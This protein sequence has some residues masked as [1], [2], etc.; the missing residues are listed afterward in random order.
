MTNNITWNYFYTCAC[1]CVFYIYVGYYYYF[2]SY[3]TL[4]WMFELSKIKADKSNFYENNLIIYD[5]KIRLVWDYTGGI[6]LM[7]NLRLYLM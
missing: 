7:L 2:D 5:T 6:K 1:D 3:K 4:A